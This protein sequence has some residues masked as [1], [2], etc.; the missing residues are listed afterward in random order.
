MKLLFAP[1]LVQL[2]AVRWDKLKRKKKT[3]DKLKMTEF[4]L[5]R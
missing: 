1:G 2:A 4:Y 3:I 5:Y